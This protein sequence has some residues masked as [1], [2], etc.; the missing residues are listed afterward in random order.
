MTLA[1]T[2][3]RP[4]TQ[5]VEE[6]KA[7]LIT[8]VRERL[9]QI[10]DTQVSYI[11]GRPDRLTLTYGFTNDKGEKF[12]LVCGPDFLTAEKTNKDWPTAMEMLDIKPKNSG[13]TSYREGFRYHES[14]EAVFTQIDELLK[15]AESRIAGFLPKLQKNRF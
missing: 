13:Y 5:S 1:E 7:T 3:E 10:P 12:H 4:Q 9:L 14:E 15:L 6:R 2:R 8:T 11:L